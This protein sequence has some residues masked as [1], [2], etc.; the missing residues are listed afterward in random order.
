MIYVCEPQY[1]G[2]SHEK[3]NSGFVHGIRLAFPDEKMTFFANKSHI[4]NMKQLLEHDKVVIPNIEYKRITTFQRYTLFGFITY[5]FLFKKLFSTVLAGGENRI[6]FLSTDPLFLFLIRKIKSQSKFKDI[7]CTFV[8]HGEFEEI[9]SASN[10]NV[11]GAPVVAGNSAQKKQRSLL[12]VVKKIPRFIKF[13]LSLLYW[14]YL[15]FLHR[16]FKNKFQTKEQLLL[17]ASDDFKFIALSPHIIPNAAKFIDA[18]KNHI[19]TVNMPI[20]FAAVAPAP[21]NDYIKFA[22]FGFG[23]LPN[24]RKVA[25]HLASKKLKN[26]YEIR[27]IGMDNRGLEEFKNVYCPSPGVPLSRRAM[28]KYAEDIDLFL[29][30]YGNHKYQLSCSGSIL[31]VLSYIKPVMHLENMCINNF[32]KPNRSIGYT[33]DSPEAMADKMADMILN[34]KNYLPEIERKR[35]NIMELREELKMENLAPKIR[36]SFSF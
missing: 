19:V 8:L 5:Y 28:E 9:A 2:I 24:L 3:V 30:M 25:L 36:E 23:D 22:T 21:K 17:S 27:I 26:P 34:Y 16:K 7:K 20:N 31:E 15:S 18:E 11:A 32:D 29:I 1:K 35:K 6:F 12:S 33:F 13:K 10:P 4:R 14:E